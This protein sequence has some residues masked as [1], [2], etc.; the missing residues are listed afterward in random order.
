MPEEI[1]QLTKDLDRVKVCVCPK[2]GTNVK[3]KENQ[4]K[5][6]NNS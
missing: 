1:R 3:I 5:N 4:S 2:Y 6:C